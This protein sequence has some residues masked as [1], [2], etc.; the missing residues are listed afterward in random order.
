MYAGKSSL[1]ARPNSATNTLDHANVK[2]AL[3]I[4][5]FLGSR[6]GISNL[7]Q[8]LDISAACSL[9]MELTGVSCVS[10]R[11]SMY[12]KEE[13][14]LPAQTCRFKIRG[15]II[16]RRR[17]RRCL[18]EKSWQRRPDIKQSIHQNIYQNVKMPA[19]AYAW[20][21]NTLKRSV[22]MPHLLPGAEFLLLQVSVVA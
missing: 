10:S 21:A 4:P 11:I 9:L 13:I 5:K 20:A 15:L 12:P 17:A 22:V 3:L 14:Y 2:S 6:K 19:L 1:E 7:F 8:N 16:V 18:L